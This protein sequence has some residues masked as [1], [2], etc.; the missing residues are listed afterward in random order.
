MNIPLIESP[1]FAGAFP[2]EQTDPEL[3]R[4]ARSLHDD[5]YAVIDFP[6]DDFDARVAAIR[7]NLQDR[8]DWEAWRS[9]RSQGL[10]IQD[11]SPRAAHAAPG[12]KSGILDTIT[13]L[14]RRA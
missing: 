11:A 1:F 6:D 9:G 3:L 5:G 14:F 13:A 4:V 12:A 2:P 10:R 8:Y 7:R